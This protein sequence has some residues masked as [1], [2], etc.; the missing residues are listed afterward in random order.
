MIW[1]PGVLSQG[2][3]VYTWNRYS[4]KYQE[5]IGA[6][7]THTFTTS[8]HLKTA[9][10][11]TT[12]GNVFTLTNY[13]NSRPE[14]IGSGDYLVSLSNMAT[15]S[16][17]ILYEVI[18]NKYESDRYTITYKPHTLE[19][20]ADKLIGTVQS[21]NLYAYPSNG[22]QDG[23]WYV[24]TDEVSP[25]TGVNY[26][27]YLQSTGTQYLNTHYVQTTQKI[28]LEFALEL[29]AD[30]TGAVAV[31]GGS[32]NAWLPSLHKPDA[33]SSPAFWIAAGAS[34]CP[35]SLTVGTRYDFVVEVNSGSVTVTVNGTTKTATYSGTM[36]TSLPF[37]I[38]AQYGGGQLTK[39]KLYYYKLSEN[40]TLVRHYKPC[41]DPDGVACAYEEVNGEYEY[42]AGSGNFIAA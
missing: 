1:L 14:Y 29:T 13:A 4:I 16:S 31:G 17:T 21:S 7:A 39:M 20:G 5:V 2:G 42:N 18:S 11:Y 32:N 33:S 26:K 40:S 34:L 35:V 36:S 23:Y 25:G 6:T 41:L 27:T 38:F 30:F 10:T 28:R 19:P 8:G 9:S 22:V 37:T 15:I 3:K 24:L 12:E